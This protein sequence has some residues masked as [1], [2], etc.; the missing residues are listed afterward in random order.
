MPSPGC[1][2]RDTLVGWNGR[3]GKRLRLPNYCIPDARQAMVRSMWH[4]TGPG[5]TQPEWDDQ[6]DSS[7]RCM[8][9]A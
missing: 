1:L 8:A 9:A 5:A 4:G 6:F 2:G 7:N 3:G